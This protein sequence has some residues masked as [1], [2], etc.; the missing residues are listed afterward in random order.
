MPDGD[1]IKA[2]SELLNFLN[3]IH[4]ISLVGHEDILMQYV[5]VA[6]YAKH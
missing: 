1:D 2:G 5:K 3:F 4:G 6:R